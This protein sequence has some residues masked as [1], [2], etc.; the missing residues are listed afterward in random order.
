MT[1]TV[2][3]L[4]I[5]PK[6]SNRGSFSSVFFLEHFY[7]FTTC[8][9]SCCFQFK[10]RS[11]S[12]YKQIQAKVYLYFSD[13]IICQ[14]IFR[15]AILNIKIDFSSIWKKVLNFWEKLEWGN[16]R[17]PVYLLKSG[18]FSFSCRRRAGHSL[19][20]NS[21]R[22]QIKSF[23]PRVFFC[24]EKQLASFIFTKQK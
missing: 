19:S 12:R 20:N 17:S 13:W 22:S 4:F 9:K 23:F 15:N 14:R 10:K 3:P 11:F 8:N 1:I 2:A 6:H 18:Q 16:Q 7:H 24:F 5:I 21:S